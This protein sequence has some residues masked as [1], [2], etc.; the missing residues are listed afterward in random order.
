MSSRTKWLS[1]LML[2]A[3]IAAGSCQ[4]NPKKENATSGNAVKV[5]TETVSSSAAENWLNYTGTV[6][7]MS[8][9]TLSFAGAGTVRRLAVGEGQSVSKGQLIG[10]IDA[11]ASSNAAA[12]AK[13]ATAQ[14]RDALSQA[15]DAYR[16]MKL[17][18]DSG[19]LPAIKWVEVE[20]R[21]S[22]AE[23]MVRQ[24]EASEQIAR[25]AQAD[26]RLYA[27]FD[28]Y[29]AAKLA[30]TGQNVMP[31]IPIVKL[32]D[33]DRVKI[34]L[35]VPESEIGRI[36][37]GDVVRFT[38]SSVGSEEFMGKI[39][40]KGVAADPL[41]RSYEVKV[42]ADNPSHRL[43]PGMVCDVSVVSPGRAAS[44]SLPANIVQIDTD[45]C[46]FVWTLS[47][48][49]AKKTMIKV[50]GYAGDR[51]LVSSGLRAGDKVIV[52]GQQKVSNGMKVSE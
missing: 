34:K 4:K 11:T 1:G 36:A 5:K 37:I 45:N 14:A 19:S 16:R 35:P 6:E 12:M 40:E 43:L 38:V 18:H 21:L 46:P 29:I 49:K 44:A 31:G 17:L 10:E 47:G 15:Q 22:Q 39:A 42:V 26:T 24:A 30:G 32:V 41:S 9:T 33:I 27:P 23:Q 13:A 50:G 51:I 52:E 20:T 2:A 25:K 28:G 8:G 3:L 7:E 48:G